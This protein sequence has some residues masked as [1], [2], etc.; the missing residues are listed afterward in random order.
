M[1]E[2]KRIEQGTDRKA[3]AVGRDELLMRH[4][5]GFLLRRHLLLLVLMSGFILRAGYAIYLGN[6]FGPV[7][8]DQDG[9]YSI[10]EGLL[11]GHGLTTGSFKRA[12]EYT[13][14]ERQELKDRYLCFT[15]R[16]GEK[17]AFWPPLYPCFLASVFAVLGK[18]LLMVRIAQALISMGSVLLV[19]KTAEHQFNK[20]VANISA[21]LLAFYPLYIYLSNQI[22]T[23]ALY[24]FL[25]ALLVYC[26]SSTGLIGKK[27]GA[28]IL[29]VTFGA[30][31]LT[32]GS[33]VMLL[34]IPIVSILFSQRT[35]RALLPVGIFIASASLTISP[36]VTRNY[37]LLGQVV[38]FPT[39]GGFNLWVGYNPYRLPG[40]VGN[41]SDF[42]GKLEALTASYTFKSAELME[43]PQLDGK[44]EQAIAREFTRRTFGFVFHNP[45]YAANLMKCKLFFLF[46]FFPGGQFGGKVLGFFFRIGH[47]FLFV[48]AF[49]GILLS[50]LRR[51]C[52]A[53]PAAVIALHTI[54]SA[55][56]LSGIRFRS[57]ID[58][59]LILYASFFAVSAFTFFSRRWES[60][61][62]FHEDRSP[63][64]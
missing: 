53:I 16:H 24:I 44:D 51:P 30:L 29:G 40:F 20:S 60:E 63:G 5:Y 13:D 38:I 58:Q 21:F 27:E 42:A 31:F 62:N 17:T 49:I 54:F 14:S 15:V 37:F 39:N 11:E 12:K 19:Y 8:G 10:A 7:V 35:R 6:S 3:K 28:F 59:F 61:A 32:R 36:W 25:L 50:L 46:R 22:L 23:E 52:S 43:V 18:E 48:A 2:T 4:S 57:P 41:R 26:C 47:A 55:A 9:Y 33:A 34:P 1:A 64:A 45:A 56:T